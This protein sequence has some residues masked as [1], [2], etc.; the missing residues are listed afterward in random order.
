MSTQAMKQEV[1]E[2]F[3]ALFGDGAK[4]NYF[5]PGR[6]NL[7]GEHTDYNGGYVFPAAISIGTFGVA[8]KRADSLVKVYSLNFETVGVIEF[9]LENE[10]VNT[11]EANWG[12]FVK[13][14]LLKLKEAGHAIQTGFELV[15]EG[16]IPNGSGLS[17]SASLELLV[18]TVVNDLYHLGLDKLT[19]V[20]LGQ[21]VENE[22]IGVNSGIMDQFAIGFGEIGKAI[23]LDTN[24]LK[25]ELVPAEFGDYKIV[26][27]NTNKRRELADSKYNERRAECEEALKRLQTK[28]EITAL[29]QLTPTEFEENRA[30]IGDVTLEKRAKHAVYEN[31]RTKLAK[32][33]L[34]A[35]ELQAFGQLLN[36]SHESLK[37]DYEVTGIELDTLAETAQGLSGV[38]GARMTGA[39]FGG[40]G[41]AL[42]AT[43]E[44]ETFITKLSATYLEK[45]GYDASFYVATIA[46][47]ARKL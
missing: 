2:K 19:L 26:I 24:T 35:G 25:Y 34:E 6:I 31:E 38:L 7:I 46:D 41:I 5:S 43:S 8:R 1:T 11:P 17:S 45:I 30:L 9:S 40:C 44:I 33:C 27:M 15:I 32:T 36:A 37:N 39:G 14:Y 3:I 20:Q 4:A 10:L 13:G 16:T 47:G 22:F 18:G 42:V 21:K 23:L 29:G 28:L 12:N